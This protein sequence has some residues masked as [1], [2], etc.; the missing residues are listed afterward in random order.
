MQ[1]YK[2]LLIKL[3]L[4]E[5]VGPVFV[6]RALSVISGI[7]DQSE[8]ISFY[9][10][11]KHDLALAL[12][13][14]IDAPIR[15]FLDA[16]ISSQKTIEKIKKSLLVVDLERELRLVEAAGVVVDSCFD[17]EYPQ[18]LQHIYAPPVVLYRLGAPVGSGEQLLAVVGA[19]DA[20]AYG[21]SCIEYLLPALVACG[22]K[23]VSGGALGVDAAAHRVSVTH[24]MPTISVLGSGLN[25]WYPYGNKSLFNEIL[26]TGGTLL[27]PF[28][29]EQRPERG[30]FPARNR[31]IA[32]IAPMTLVI[33]AGEKSGALISAAYA[34]DSGRTVGVVPGSILS[35]QSI[36]CHKLLKQGALIVSGPE[37]L[38]AELG[39][40]IIAESEQD[41]P[42]VS[43]MGTDLGK[44]QDLFHFIATTARSEEEIAD[45]LKKD[46]SKTQ[47]LLFDLQLDGKIMQQF[48]GL[49]GISR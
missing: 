23:I 40:G 4:A 34:L 10:Q 13:Q 26:K 37:D 11:R 20:T 44:E 16:G 41:S 48:T 9:A 1:T 36:G 2:R 17:D 28:S 42:V 19:R 43:T 45:F 27:S 18:L 49:W 22:V 30:T 6:Y 12:Q 25:Y 32:G 39:L 35:P 14:I 47:E 29:M 3:L 15:F 38:C 31:V 7:S 5:N 24:K 21:L 8:V 46:L 33:E